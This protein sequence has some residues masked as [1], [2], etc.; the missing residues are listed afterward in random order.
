MEREREREEERTRELLEEN[1]DGT[2]DSEFIDGSDIEEEDHV[3]VF[4]EYTY[5]EQDGKDFEQ[6]M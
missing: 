1:I 2:S 3:D 6:E 5:S 4:H